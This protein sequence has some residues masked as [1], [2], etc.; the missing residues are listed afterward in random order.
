MAQ[1]ATKRIVRAPRLKKFY[2]LASRCQTC[3]KPILPGQ[4]W[5]FTP[6]GGKV[7]YYCAQNPASTDYNW[8]SEETT[9]H[10]DSLTDAQLKRRLGIVQP[11]INRARGPGT[12]SVAHAAVFLNLQDQEQAIIQARLRKFDRKSG[13]QNP[14]GPILHNPAVDGGFYDPTGRNEGYI[15]FRRY[16]GKLISDRVA[17]RANLSRIGWHGSTLLTDA[18]IDRVHDLIA[19][20]GWHYGVEVLEPEENPA[21]PTFSQA[22]VAARQAGARIGDT[23]GFEPWLVK[24]QLDTRGPQVRSRL[25]REFWRGVEEGEGRTETSSFEYKGATIYRLA[26]GYQVSIDPDSR[27]DSL[28]DAKQFVD[29]QRRNPKLQLTDRAYRYRANSHPPSDPKLC[30]FC[31]TN[32]QVQVGHVDGHEENGEPENLIWTCR[33]CNMLHAN[34]LRAA[35]YGRLTRQY[36]P[37]ARG[38]ESYRQYALALLSMKGESDAMSVPTAVEMVHATSADDRSRFSREIW[39]LRRRHYGH[40]GVYRRTA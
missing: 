28:K 2:A 8:F 25:E 13:R 12:E 23:S 7:H 34:T 27:F 17:D 29:A 36:N 31:G 6:E 40:T 24:A 10:L 30:A 11:Q 35:G 3:E 4:T 1:A 18:D 33:S 15:R 32:R 19:K 39:R 16:H 5:Q 21:G 38:A 14:A 9:R 26:D 37:A 22:M 20:S